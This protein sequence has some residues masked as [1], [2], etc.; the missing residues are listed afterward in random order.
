MRFDFRLVTSLTTR[1]AYLE[2]LGPTSPLDF[3]QV[4]D[5]VNLARQPQVL[6]ITGLDDGFIMG[7]L[8][9]GWQGY[10]GG[11]HRLR[12]EAWDIFG[13]RG[14]TIH[15][16]LRY[17]TSA[18][19]RSSNMLARVWAAGSGLGSQAPGSLVDGHGY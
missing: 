7:G 4:V 5:T 17:A 10:M 9:G 19:M 11:K 16:R 12:I 15:T 18:V 8:V 14:L 3:A 1:L 6:G 2:D 13:E